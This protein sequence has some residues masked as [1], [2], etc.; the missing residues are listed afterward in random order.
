MESLLFTGFS[1]TSRRNTTN[2]GGMIGFSAVCDKYNK[3]AE[4]LKMPIIFAQ[5]AGVSPGYTPGN[6]SFTKMLIHSDTTNGSTTFTDSSTGGGGSPHTLT[7]YNGAQ[8]STDRQKFGATSIRCQS[9][10]T[11]YVESPDSAD[12]SLGT[13][14]FAIDC[15]VNFNTMVNGN[16][17]VSQFH[18]G[19]GINESWFFSYNHPTTELVFN[20]T[21][22]GQNNLSMDRTWTPIVNTWYHVAV[23]RDGA[24]LRM[25]VDGTQVGTTYNISTNSIYNSNAAFRLGAIRINGSIWTTDILDG[26]LDEVRFS[27]GTPRWTSNFTPPTLP[28]GP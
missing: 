20:Y 12:W 18:G 13:S 9:G 17:M 23:T 16:I 27:V 22:D 14:D 7:G 11:E 1:T 15:W 3:P 25:F 4:R 2:P 24:N 26:Y 19:S 10:D 8:H 21:L 5:P 6:D 28:Y